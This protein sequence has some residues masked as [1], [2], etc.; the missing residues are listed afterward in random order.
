MFTFVRF[1]FLFNLNVLVIDLL[2]PEFVGRIFKVVLIKAK[3]KGTEGCKLYFVTEKGVILIQGWGKN[4]VS[5]MTSLAVE[6]LQLQAS[7]GG[8]G[9]HRFRL[10]FFFCFFVFFFF[11]FSFFLFEWIDVVVLFFR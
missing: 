9:G 8:P 3:E 5:E 2:E 10:V 6:P 11:F 4:L 1:L 7:N